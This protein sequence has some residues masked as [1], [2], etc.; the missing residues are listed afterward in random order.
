MRDDLVRLA[1]LDDGESDPSEDLR[2]VL[3]RGA[4]TPSGSRLLERVGTLLGVSWGRATVSSIYASA[5]RPD[6][7]SALGEVFAE[8]ATS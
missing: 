2:S 5:D 6:T 3:H 7:L 1:L 4:L 8:A